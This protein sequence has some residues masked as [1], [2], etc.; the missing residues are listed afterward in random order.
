M[1]IYIRIYGGL[2]ASRARSYSFETVNETLLLK[3][4]LTPL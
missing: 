3:P 4:P 2:R 1:Y